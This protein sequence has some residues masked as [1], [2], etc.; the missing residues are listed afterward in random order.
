[1]HG[2]AT[3]SARRAENTAN[4]RGLDQGGL[5][6]CEWRDTCGSD[7]MNSGARDAHKHCVRCRWLPGDSQAK[8]FLIKSTVQPL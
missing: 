4:T 6:E 3:N 7:E 8:D 1:M 2:G 5:G